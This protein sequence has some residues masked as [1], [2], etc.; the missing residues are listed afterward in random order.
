VFQQMRQRG[1]VGQ[2]VN[3]DEIDLFVAQCCTHD[4]AADAAE[5]V[6]PD[7]HSHYASGQPSSG[8]KNDER[9]KRNS[10]VRSLPRGNPRLPTFMYF[11]YSLLILLFGVVASPYL[12]YQAL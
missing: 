11:I 5:P 3:R 7:F 10:N 8:P 1:G 9:Q 6:D 4:V 12:A 2:V